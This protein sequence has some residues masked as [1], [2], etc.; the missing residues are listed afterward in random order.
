MD[1]LVA[2]LLIGVVV[3]YMY[4]TQ[5][6][7][8]RFKQGTE[9]LLQGDGV[10]RSLEER[11]KLLERFAITEVARGWRLISQSDEIVVLEYGKRPN[12]I[13]HFLLCIPTLG[14]WIIIWLLLSFSMNIKRKTY[15]INEYGVIKEY[16]SVYTG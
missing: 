10:K 2:S 1:V 12:H 11:K 6:N 9:K 3:F 15:T 13:L 5:K 4:K 7:R 14:F 16:L 8:K